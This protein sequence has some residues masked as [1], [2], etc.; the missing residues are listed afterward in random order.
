MDYIRQLSS[1]DLNDLAVKDMAFLRALLDSVNDVPHVTMVVVMIASDKD[2]MDLDEAG[3]SR[4]DELEQ[5]LDRNGWPGTINDNNDFAAILRRRLFDAKPPSE[6]L[7]ATAAVFARAMTEAWRTKVFDAL[8][9]PWTREWDAAVARCYPFHPQLMHLAEQEW[10]K[11]SGFQ[12][13][14]STIQIFAATA[15]TLAQRARQGEWA[16]LLVGPGDL[17]LSES[18]VR[19]AIIGSGLISDTRTQANYRSIASAD[20][21]VATGR[22]AQRT[23]WTGS[24]QVRHLPP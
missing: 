4:R 14:R 5:L 22:Q 15:Y 11:L 8:G 9:V 3:R 23:R 24:A 20:I 21:V 2:R 19:E 18:T 7:T 12:R 10:A 13:V 6:I 17:P 16:P 1:G